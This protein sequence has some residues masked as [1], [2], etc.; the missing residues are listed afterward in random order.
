MT[1]SASFS[2]KMIRNTMAVVLIGSISG[3][4]IFQNFCQPVAPST[5]AASEMSLGRA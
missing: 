2:L 5:S 1:R 3:K 4:V